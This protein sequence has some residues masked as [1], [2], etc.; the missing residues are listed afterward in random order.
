[1]KMNRKAAAMMAAVMAVS[2]LAGCGR[3]ETI[4]TGTAKE[5]SKESGG[6]DREGVK[7]DS[8]TESSGSEG[9]A[10]SG[11]EL[12]A[13]ET[14]QAAP[15]Q[16]DTLLSGGAPEADPAL[17]PDAG[18]QISGDS[19][20]SADSASGDGAMFLANTGM[21]KEEA[22][23]FISGFLE[24]V[25]ADDRSAVAAMIAYP[26]AVKTPS[27]EGTVA[28]AEEFLSHYDEIFTEEFK[29]KL[30]SVSASDVFYRNGMISVDDGCLWFNPATVESDM[31]VSTINA[32]ADRYVRY[33]GPQGVQPG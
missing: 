3:Y 19:A 32:A 28:G 29:Q 21:S 5:A 31:C 2:Q 1:M 23:S 30:G 18:Q 7:V 10:A 27:Y 33:D 22:S 4:E 25:K 8:E 14:N 24:A 17:Q 12:A 6:A 26:R 9:A 11:G 16:E 15:Q 20:L 13:G